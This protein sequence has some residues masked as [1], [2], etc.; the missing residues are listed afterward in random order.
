[1]K[2]SQLYLIFMM[3]T[4]IITILNFTK[5]SIKEWALLILAIEFGVIAIVWSITESREKLK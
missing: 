4:I 2:N 3:V 5:D 1:M